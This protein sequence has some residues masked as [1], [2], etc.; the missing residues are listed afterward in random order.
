MNIEEVILV[1]IMPI[2]ISF[3]Y[4]WLVSGFLSDV[5]ISRITKAS[6]E[7]SPSNIID[8]GFGYFLG[9]LVFTYIVHQFV[10]YSLV[11][12]DASSGVLVVI[13]GLTFLYLGRIVTK[14]KGIF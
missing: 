13:I 5:F 4:I 6:F 1:V 9:M 3:I 7:I 12:I 14:N 2:F 10:K 11:S 8:L